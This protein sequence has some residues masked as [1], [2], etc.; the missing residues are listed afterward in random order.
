VVGGRILTDS[1]AGIRN[2]QVAITFPSGEIRTSV[3]KTF[4]YYRCAE[5][6]VGAVYVISVSAKKFT[7]AQPSQVRQV[8]DDLQDV[9][10]IAD[11][12]D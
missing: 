9:D 2:V 7:F 3:S 8:Q 4:G 12:M 5:I 1:G 10:F 11:A 6:P